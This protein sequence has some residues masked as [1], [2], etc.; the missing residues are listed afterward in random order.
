MHKY[1]VFYKV[2]RE[3][4]EKNN[5]TRGLYGIWYGYYHFHNWKGRQ[6][7]VYVAF[8][9]SM[10]P[11]RLLFSVL[12]YRYLVVCISSQSIWIASS[13]VL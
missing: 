6:I 5:N 11:N 8:V 2:F 3:V 7:V 12:L 13:F 1:I 9:S 10:V 4:A